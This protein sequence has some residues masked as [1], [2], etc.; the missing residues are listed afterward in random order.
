[1]TRR[2]RVTA[3]VIAILA[4][5]ALGAG[6]GVAWWAWSPDVVVVVSG[7]NAYPEGFQPRGF[8]T[9]DVLA[10][11]LAILGG[12]VCGGASL[13]LL[14]RRFGGARGDLPALALA[15]VAAVPGVAMLWFVGTRLGSGDL[16]AAVAAAADGDR[17]IAPLTLRMPGVLVLWPLASAVVVFVT[18]VATW[19][20]GRVSAPTPSAAA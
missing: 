18:A 20:V 15:L 19:V 7:D 10:A 2:R 4:A 6:L 17:L 8:A 9:S 14:R 5:T 3:L 13:I 12:L 16:A 11:A 1:M